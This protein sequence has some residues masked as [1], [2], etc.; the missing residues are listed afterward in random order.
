MVSPKHETDPQPSAG[1]GSVNRRTI[2]G[3]AGWAA[4]AIALSVASPA[5]AASLG[6]ITASP[7][8]IAAGSTKSSQLQLNPAAD[9]ITIS[10]SAEPEGIV[11]FPAAVTTFPGLRGS[12]S[13][14]FSTT[15][16]EA[17]V[18]MITAVAPGYTPVTFALPIEA[19]PVVEPEPT[20][21][22]I[23]LVDA[24]V[25][26]LFN[27]SAPN[28]YPLEFALSPAASGVPVTLTPV[29]G[30]T[31]GLVGM[32][33][34]DLTTDAS[35][36]AK[37]TVGAMYDVD[38]AVTVR[39]TAPGYETLEFVINT[40]AAGSTEPTNPGQPGSGGTSTH[41]VYRVSV[42]GHVA[43][44]AW[45]QYVIGDKPIVVTLGITPRA[46][47]VPTKANVAGY[48]WGGEPNVLLLSPANLAI[49]EDTPG[50]FTITKL[51]GARSGQTAT[52]MWGNYTTE[53]SIT[54]TVA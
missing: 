25:Y 2:V 18:V 38:D 36:H 8:A 16:T 43:A 30:T 53:L 33:S 50:S 24:P 10:L 32:A 5:A 28:R 47:G 34:H 19:A 26:A 6:T 39:A 27:G 31:G 22:V 3:A 20:P 12:A 48:R 54:F 41:K 44:P 9:N 29:R 46:P 14:P 11:T 42:T 1:A 4:P 37:T 40:L 21:P 7:Q 15:A 23:T 51:A 52:F 13:V 45:D 17:Q 35:G 49:T